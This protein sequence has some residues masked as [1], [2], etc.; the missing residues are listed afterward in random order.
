VI[1][2]PARLL[3]LLL[4]ACGAR[5]PGPEDMGD[6]GPSQPTVSELDPPPG[7]VPPDAAFTVRFSAAMDEGQMLAASGRSESVVLAAEADAERAAAAIEH[8]PLSA[9]ERVLLVPAAAAIASDRRSITLAPEQPLSPG[10]WVLLVSPRLKDEAGRKLSGNGRRFSFQVAPPP[11]TARLIA[12]PPG[13]EVPWNLGVVRAF[14][15]SGHVALLGP[16]GEEIASAEASGAVALPL[17]LP[18]TPGAEYSL[19]LAGAAIPS[20]SFSAAA[21]AR[22]AAP[23]LL[24]EAQLSVRDTGVAVQFVL[25]W[26]AQVELEVEDASGGSI[27]TAAEVLCAPP[28]CGP[29]SFACPGSVR[30]EGLRPAADYTLR[31]GARDDYGFTV[32][33]PPQAFSTLA[34]LPRALLSEVMASGI[35]GEYV[36]VLNLG[37]GSADL[38]TL[39]LQGADGAVRPL[40]GGAPPLPAVLA[41]GARA[42]AVGAS[43]DAALYPAIPPG[44]QVLRAATQRLLGRGLSDDAQGPFALVAQGLVPVALA[45]FPGGAPRCP[46]GVSLQR[47]EALPPDA[48][49]TWACGRGGG[50]PGRPP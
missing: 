18:L 14:A 47:D 13:G 49:A 8:A 35:E 39:A 38:E 21:C 46:V 20:Q 3:L 2:S 11:P 19:A 37:P 6:A 50:T 7:V 33:A 29:Q 36:E 23:A 16:S 40:L 1:R 43:F 4:L 17:P 28:P 22:S 9:H 15:P 26:P 25:D 27:A 45:V 24:G 48:A 41:P 32:R 5:I 34:A 31:L 44:T 30:I 10:A 42:L 12:P